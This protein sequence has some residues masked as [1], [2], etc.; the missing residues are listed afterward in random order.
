MKNIL[1]IVFLLLSTSI[2]AQLV[3]VEGSKAIGFSGGYVKNGFNISSRISLYKNNSIALRGSLDFESVKFDISKASVFYVNPELLYSFYN[4]GEN[5]FFSA[6]GGMLLG[7]ESI[8]NSILEKNKNQFFIGE[9]IGLGI[10]YYVSNKVMI[11]LDIDQRF[12]QLSKLGNAS[13]I[14]KFGINYN[15]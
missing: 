5:V 14:I 2:S 11:N 7:V 15:F 8:K 4:L 6:K 9:N 10:E 12:F 1:I 13:F 3:H